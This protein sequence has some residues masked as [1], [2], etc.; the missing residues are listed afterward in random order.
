M[1]EA[2]GRIFQLMV[3]IIPVLA[4][5]SD[6]KAPPQNWRDK[7]ERKL[8]ILRLVGLADTLQ[9]D[10]SQALKMEQVT[11]PFDD[12]RRALETEIARWAELLKKASEGE[13]AA[14]SQVDQAISGILDARSQVQALNRE[15]INALS[16]DLSPQQRA[17]MAIFFAQFENDMRRMHQQF[18]MARFRRQAFRSQWGGGAEDKPSGP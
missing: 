14:L 16:R 15:L 13:S 2:L 1:G 6:G 17:K 18:E 7:N 12:R 9:L 4:L 5:G 10:E 8:R 11:R 3:L